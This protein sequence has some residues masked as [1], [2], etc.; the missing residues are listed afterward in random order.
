MGGER[1]HGWGARERRPLLMLGPMRS[2]LTDLGR[3]LPIT[4]LGAQLRRPAVTRLGDGIKLEACLEA[5]AREGEIT[6]V[7]LGTWDG[8]SPGSPSSRPCGREGANC[9]KIS[10]SPGSLESLAQLGMNTKGRHSFH[11][12]PV[13]LLPLPLLQDLS[14]PSGFPSP[15][16]SSKHLSLARSLSNGSNSRIGKRNRPADNDHISVPAGGWSR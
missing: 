1:D 3:C 6:N 7:R 10:L 5:G 11:P 16:Q 4:A 12:M 14:C 2:S 13:A 8:S 15:S 9:S